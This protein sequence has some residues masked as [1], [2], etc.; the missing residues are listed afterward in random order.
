VKHFPF[1]VSRSLSAPP[2][3]RSAIQLPWVSC[4]FNG[5]TRTSP[6]MRRAVHSRLG[7]AL[8]FSQPR[9]GFLAD[10]SFA[11]LFH[12]ATVPGILPS[13]SFPH[14]DRVPLSRPPSS[15]AVIH[16]RALA[17]HPS[18]YY[19]RFHQL[20]RFHAVAWIPT[21]AISFHSVNRSPLPGHPG[22]RAT[23]PPRPASFT[24]FEASIPLRVRS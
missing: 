12:A 8:R 24:D 16:R 20:P 19:H 22:P 9:S 6:T 10:P 3:C 5:N 14:R 17:S 23:E 7:S 2:S 1:R 4:P 21:A 13:E 11:A 15:L 18:P